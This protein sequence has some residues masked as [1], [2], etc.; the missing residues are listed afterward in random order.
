[1]ILHFFKPNGNSLILETKVEMI[2]EETA[3]LR[4]FL[5]NHTAI[6]KRAM[7]DA[8]PSDVGCLSIASAGDLVNYPKP[9][10]LTTLFS[11]LDYFS[12]KCLHQ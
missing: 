1:M 2:R 7:R 12:I 6:S 9:V 8:C 11:Y 4:V 3:R 10:R 5:S